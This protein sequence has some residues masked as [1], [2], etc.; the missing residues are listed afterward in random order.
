MVKGKA[1]HSVK[2]VGQLQETPGTSLK[3]ETGLQIEAKLNRCT[4]KASC[5]VNPADIWDYSGSGSFRVLYVSAVCRPR[6]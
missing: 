2:A 1:N 6:V 4:R 5:Q 3:R